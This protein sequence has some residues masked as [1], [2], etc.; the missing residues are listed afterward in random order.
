MT[1]TATPEFNNLANFACSDGWGKAHVVVNRAGGMLVDHDFAIPWRETKFEQAANFD[2]AL[3]GLFL[4]IELIQPR[5]SGPRAAAIHARPILRFRPRNTIGLRSSIR[6][7]VCA[8]AGGLF[9]RFMPPSMPI[10][11]T[12]TTIR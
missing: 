10:F 8:L 3:K 11:A 7:Q 6:S 5:R 9:R 4:H 1:S 2:G 12:A